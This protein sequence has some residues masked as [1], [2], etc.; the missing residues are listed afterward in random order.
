MKRAINDE[1]PHERNQRQRTMS[2]GELNE[3]GNRSCEERGN[4][5]SD[6][7]SMANVEGVTEQVSIYNDNLSLLLSYWSI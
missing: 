4:E 3:H 6:V 7:G 5:R 2:S 1:R